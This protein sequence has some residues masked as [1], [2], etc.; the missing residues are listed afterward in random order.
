MCVCVGPAALLASVL[1]VVL[2]NLLVVLEVEE[3]LEVGE[4]VL[5]MDGPVHLTR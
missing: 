2:V 1:W 5:E 3:V 4:E